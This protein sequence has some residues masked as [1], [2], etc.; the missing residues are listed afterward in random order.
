[1]QPQVA[2]DDH[3]S[4]EICPKLCVLEP[5]RSQTSPGAAPLL[6]CPQIGAGIVRRS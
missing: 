2:T 3:F 6:T 4:D 1:M 5:V